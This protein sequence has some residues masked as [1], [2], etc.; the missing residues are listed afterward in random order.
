MNPNP[1]GPPNVGPNGQH[2][3]GIIIA[4]LRNQGPSPAGWQQTTPLDVRVNLVFSLYSQLQLINGP[5]TST[6]QVALNFEQQRFRQSTTKE[7]YVGSVKAKLGEVTSSRQKLADQRGLPQGNLQQ[8]GMMMQP[9]GMHNPMQPQTPNPGTQQAFN[10]QLQQQMRATPI[11]QN[12]QQPQNAASMGMGMGMANSNMP[13][14][15]QY[16]PQAGMVPQP[17]NLLTEGQKSMIQNYAMRMT[18][19]VRSNQEEVTR[20]LQN[21]NPQQRQ[22]AQSKGLDPIAALFRRQA[23]ALL[24]T[25]NPQQLQQQLQ[26]TL[27]R[28]APGQNMMGGMGGIA[29][30]NQQP[31]FGRGQPQMPTGQGQVNQFSESSDVD[32]SQ[33]LGQQAD[34]QK[35]QDAGQ[36]VVPASNNQTVAPQMSAQQSSGPANQMTQQQMM[37]PQQNAMRTAHMQAQERAKLQQQQLHAAQAAQ[38]QQMTLQGQIGGLSN[39]Q[40]PH[41]SP[42]M[43]N[44]NRPLGPPGGNNTP[45]PRQHP[46]PQPGLQPSPVAMENRMSQPGQMGFAN[47]QGPG[48]GPVPGPGPGAGPTIPPQAMHRLNRIPQG[49]NPQLRKQLMNLPEPQ[50]NAQIQVLQQQIANRAMQQQQGLP[51]QLGMQPGGTPIRQNPMGQSQPTPNGNTAPSLGAGFQQMPNGAN[52]VLAVQAQEIR[53]Q[54]LQTPD[55]ISHWDARPATPAVRSAIPGLPDQYQTWGQVKAYLHSNPVLQQNLSKKVEGAQ[56]TQFAQMYLVQ[57]Q[58]QQRQQ[59]QAAAMRNQGQMGNMQNENIMGTINGQAPTAPMVTNGQPQV[60]PQARVGMLPNARG[61]LQ[62]FANVPQPTMQEVQQA[63]M[64]YGQSLQHLT[65]DQLKQKIFQNKQ[66]SAEGQAQQ[67]TNQVNQQSAVGTNQAQQPRTQAQQSMTQPPQPI[68]TPKPPAKSQTPAK[69]TQPAPNNSSAQG[70]QTPRGQKRPASNDDVVEVSP[71]TAVASAKNVSQGMQQT[72][73][74]QG[75]QK[76]NQ[77]QASNQF[78]EERQKAQEQIRKQAITKASANATK[79]QEQVNSASQGSTVPSGSGPTAEQYLQR[80]QKFSAITKEIREAHAGTTSV[81]NLQPEQKQTYSNQLQNAE[82]MIAQV[83]RVIQGFYGHFQDEAFTRQLLQPLVL[84]RLAKAHQSQDR[85][86]MTPEQLNVVLNALKTAAQ[87]MFT[88]VNTAKAQVAQAV[89]AALAVQAQVQAQAQTQAQA[90]AQAKVKVQPASAE[91]Q[92]PLNAAN[93]QQHEKDTN[94]AR[95]NSMHKRNSSKPPAAPTEKQP[96]FRLGAASPSG[97]PAA[98]GPGAHQLTQDKLSLPPSRKKQKTAAGSAATTPGQQQPTPASISSPQLTKSPELMRQPMHEP[99]KPIP[100]KAMMFKCQYD[101][102]EHKS[103]G[104]SS[105]AELDRHEV[106]DHPYIQNALFFA[107]QAFADA[108]NLDANGVPKQSPATEANQQKEKFGSETKTGRPETGTPANVTT[109]PMARTATQQGTQASPA[110]KTPQNQGLGK[111]QTPASGATS[112]KTTPPQPAK[113]ETQGLKTMMD[114]TSDKDSLFDDDDDAMDE[115][116][117]ANTYPALSAFRDAMADQVNPNFLHNYHNTITPPAVD[118]ENEPAKSSPPRSTP[119]LSPSNT[120]TPK[121]KDEFMGFKE[122]DLNDKEAHY[123]TTEWDP[124]DLKSSNLAHLVHDDSL[125]DDGSKPL[126]PIENEKD[127]DGATTATGAK[128][129]WKDSRLSPLGKFNTWAH[130]HGLLEDDE[131][132]TKNGHFTLDFPMTPPSPGAVEPYD[133]EG[134]LMFDGSRPRT[135]MEAMFAEPMW[136]GDD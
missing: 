110:I 69:A 80:A 40:P 50:F 15:A 31:G 41:P 17:Q 25:G 76:P 85:Y 84:L 87:A 14:M 115:G 96:P 65:D 81:Q 130:G 127:G 131:M 56:A 83:Q 3:R 10:P 94:M 61:N 64:K 42:A 62:A 29:P 11:S 30:Q 18:Q 22:D 124:F 104:F 100:P 72:K 132:D 134:L 66:R 33:F 75:G 77:P 135:D 43:P 51:P 13:P 74:Q 70:Q 78:L 102:C 52:N 105:Q 8:M 19:I 26:N 128:N 63:R 114:D 6:L 101:D 116:A 86:I 88:R 133:P 59:A 20:V 129:I 68:P 49:V 36:L 58:Q 38:A 120:A 82:N 97:A 136:I 54:F 123:L 117:F 48:P 109:T 121:S 125:D 2:V 98:Y 60:P 32:M 16:N 24:Q 107:L 95:Q 91:S 39:P 7:E 4:A 12:Q 55:K 9:N 108:A 47:P 23:V 118:R 44:L 119:N 126:F 27:N 106:D 93:L 5:S 45:Q 1:N 122:P 57:Q 103:R 35:S 111:T 112:S 67:Q 37:N 90:Q 71:P 46:G 92:P 113:T 53:R 21:M 89:Q 28:L 79:Q 34:A 73:S 99:T